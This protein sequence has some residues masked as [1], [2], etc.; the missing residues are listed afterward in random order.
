MIDILSK[1]TVLLCLQQQTPVVRRI[2]NREIGQVK[3][4]AEREK[5]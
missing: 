4:G 5:E 2:N 1:T 3:T